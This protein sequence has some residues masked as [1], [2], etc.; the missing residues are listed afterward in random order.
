MQSHSSLLELMESTKLYGAKRT[1]PNAV[2]PGYKGV[3]QLT[4]QS[5]TGGM[6]KFPVSAGM[7]LT[8]EI[9][10]EERTVMQYLL[11]PVQRVSNEAGR[12]R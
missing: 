4:E 1:D 9:I 3:G 5:L 11:S 10:E 2:P 7:Q 12:E 8:A 6:G